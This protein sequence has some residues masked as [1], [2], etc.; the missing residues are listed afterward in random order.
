MLLS[1]TGFVGLGSDNLT[2]GSGGFCTMRL[3]RILLS[4]VDMS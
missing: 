4:S 2:K 1:D 3:H